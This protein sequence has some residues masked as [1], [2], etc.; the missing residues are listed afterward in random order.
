MKPKK[1]KSKVRKRKVLRKSR[2]SAE[3]SSDI[4]QEHDRQQM[5]LDGRDEHRGKC[6]G[7]SCASDEMRK[8]H[9]FGRW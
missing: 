1:P 8:V 2:K 9:P 3:S 4:Q 5:I 7:M 6:T